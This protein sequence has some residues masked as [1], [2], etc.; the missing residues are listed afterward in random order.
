MPGPRSASVNTWIWIR[1]HMNTGE[2]WTLT[3]EAWR[4]KMESWRAYI[5]V[6]ADSH[7]SDKEQEHDPDQDRI[8][9]NVT[10]WV[11]IRIRSEVKG[12]IRIHALK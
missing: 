4:L 5:P 10:D 1:K 3:V 2:P 11:R 12:W 9:I 6:V 8:H 7:Q